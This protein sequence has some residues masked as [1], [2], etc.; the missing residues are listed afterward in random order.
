MKLKPGVDVLGIKP[1]LLL[2]LQVA[3]PGLFISRRAKGAAS[4]IKS[5]C[6]ST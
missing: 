3:E 5:V 1:E 6:S 4:R 2:G